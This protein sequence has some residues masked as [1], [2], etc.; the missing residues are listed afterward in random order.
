[1]AHDVHQQG[2]R[3]VARD[4]RLARIEHRVERLGGEAV[5]D[6]AAGGTVA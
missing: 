5:E 1:L 3:E 2:R 6:V 4:R